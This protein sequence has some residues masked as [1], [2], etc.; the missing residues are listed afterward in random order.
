MPKS[1][2]YLQKTFL[3]FSFFIASCSSS[4]YPM[5][6]QPDD[7]VGISIPSRSFLPPAL[8]SGTALNL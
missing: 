2:S 8:E 7:Q 6:P 3:F 5:E 1:R 4:L